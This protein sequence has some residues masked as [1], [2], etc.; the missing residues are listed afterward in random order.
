MH[1]LFVCHGNVCR[2]ALSEYL[3]RDALRAR[4]VTEHTPG[5]VTVSSCGLLRLDG[6]AMDDHYVDLLAARGIDGTPHRSTPFTPA[7][8]KAADLT[9]VFTEEQL[10][11][12]LGYA[13]A[14]AR[15]TYLMDDFA[16]L[17]AACM[18]DGDL[19]G[20]GTAAVNPDE[21]LQSILLAAPF[22]RPLL[23]R[24]HDIRDPHR[25]DDTVYAQVA[26]EIVSRID[27]IADALAGAARA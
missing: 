17:C 27:V 18:A 13:P 15:T 5:G 2:S 9:I 23:P 12:L 20:G 7:L 26:D 19:P 11:E 21:R 14:A 3:L 6:L 24:P 22:K 10:D 25:R 4:G 16:N 8:A 1:I